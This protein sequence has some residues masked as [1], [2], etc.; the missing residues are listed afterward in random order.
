MDKS[1][2]AYWLVQTERIPR[3]LG[4]VSIFRNKYTCETTISVK[5]Q[6]N[7]V[8]QELQFAFTVR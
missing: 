5:N 8:M 6:L 3:G 7:S 1:K 4:L 2:L